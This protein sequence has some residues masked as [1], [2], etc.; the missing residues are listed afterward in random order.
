MK[1]PYAWFDLV[2][3]SGRTAVA[4]IGVAFSV[5]LILMQVGFF[6]AVWRSAV[7]VP[8]RLDFDLIITST[9]YSFLSRSG[10]VSMRRLRQ[11]SAV[12]GVTAVRPL[13]VVLLPWHA[14]D[15][16]EARAVASGRPILVLAVDAA[17]PPFCVG[18]LADAPAL[19]APP[20]AVLIDSRS[21]Q[22]FGRQEP[23]TV[24]DLA[25]HEVAIAGRFQMGTGFSADGAVITSRR[26]LA[27]IVPGLGTEEV[28]LGLVSVA[29]GADPAAVTRRLRADLPDDVR[30]LSRK[31][32]AWIER[33]HWIFDT[34]VGVIFGMGA[35]TSFVVGMAIVSQV[36]AN[37]VTN[38]F[39]EYATMKAL[40]YP[41]RFISNVVLFQA[42][43]IALVGFV[44]GC[45]VAAVLYRLTD[46]F[47]F[48]PMRLGLAEGLAV[49][50]LAVAMCVAAALLAV[51]KVSLAAPA[52]LF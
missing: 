10:T 1:V 15:T 40:G 38:H 19:L 43:L 49:L 12:E 3:D 2:H 44:P 14:G 47:A 21:R 33:R 26:T 48:I 29:P 8:N 7:L 22:H 25:G 31:E 17:T 34:S 30:I 51:R 37:K 23:G 13:E 35:L 11:A 20:D 5:L 50:A 41:Q 42:I 28:S 18:L 32:L 39:R 6:G 36:L 9:D 45:A 16:R 46:L 52:D 24:A 27:R 4:I